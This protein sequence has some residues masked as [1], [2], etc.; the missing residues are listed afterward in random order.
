MYFVLPILKERREGLCKCL[1]VLLPEKYSEGGL[2]VNG[3]CGAENFG[4]MAI[5]WAQWG[6]GPTGKWWNVMSNAKVAPKKTSNSLD[7]SNS[8]IPRQ[9]AAGFFIDGQ[10]TTRSPS[11]FNLS[12]P[13]TFTIG[14]VAVN[15]A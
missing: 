13:K 9:L 15:I 14:I 2:T 3:N 1:R 10:S 11:L 5:T 12:L 7:S 6:S 8:L 4:Q